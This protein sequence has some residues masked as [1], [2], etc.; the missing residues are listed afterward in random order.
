MVPI[1][2]SLVVEIVVA[3]VVL[4]IGIYFSSRDN[5]SW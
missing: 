2:W 3:G 1:A 5:P 4:G